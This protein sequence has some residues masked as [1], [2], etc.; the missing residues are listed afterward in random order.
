MS[1]VVSAVYDA[2]GIVFQVQRYCLYDG[3]GIRTTVFLKGCP[4]RCEWCH[5][6]ESHLFQPEP[7]RVKGRNG[8]KEEIRGKRMSVEEVMEAVDRDRS[9]YTGSG[10][11]V[12][13]SGGEPL[14]QIEFLEQLLAASK[15]RGYHTVVE[16]AGDVPWS[17][18]LSTLPFVDLFLYDVKVMDPG[19]HKAVTGVSNERILGNL[20]KL[21]EESKIPLWIRIPIVPGVNDHTA[22]MEA[23]ARRIQPL[24]NIERVQLLPYHKSG[25]SKYAALGRSCPTSDLSPPSPEHMRRLE[26]VFIR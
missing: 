19:I 16:T 22:A 8:Y 26:E 13:F 15:E 1:S 4:M 23:I 12:T 25:E 14:M 20:Q 3:P 17:R 21:S 11:G 2:A 24:R 10:G 7:M 9:F 5:N 18:F 6:P